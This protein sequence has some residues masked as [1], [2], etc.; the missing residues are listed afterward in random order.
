MYVL[1]TNVRVIF[2]GNARMVQNQPTLA[3]KWK[4]VSLGAFL[5][6]RS[7]RNYSELRKGQ[8]TLERTGQKK[9]LLPWQS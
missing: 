5:T 3:T 4:T 1:I 2:L 9:K 6:Q 7:T 8:N